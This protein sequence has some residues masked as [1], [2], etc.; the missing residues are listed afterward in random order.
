MEHLSHDH[1]DRPN[2]QENSH[3]LCNEMRNPVVNM[4]EGKWK[5]RQQHDQNFAKEEKPLQNKY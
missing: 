5:L 4:M 3:K 1:Q 2:Q